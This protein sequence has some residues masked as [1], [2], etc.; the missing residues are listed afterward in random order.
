MKLE[1]TIKLNN[2]LDNNLNLEKMQNNF[3]D[4]TLGKV[5][6]GGIDLGLRAILPDFV[7]DQVISVKDSLVNAGLNNGISKTIEGAIN[8]GKNVLGIVTK[9]IQDV[10]QM[11]SIIKNGGLIG[12][13]SKVLDSTLNQA[14]NNN[15]INSNIYNKV[16]QGKK[17]ILN[18]IEQNIDKSIK[19]QE[20]S[21]NNLET[22]INNW[23][24]YYNNHDFPNMEKQY[25]KIKKELKNLIPLE[26]TISDAR[27]VENIHTLIKTNG[28][29]FNLDKTE[30]ELIKK[31]S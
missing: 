15:E 5:I 22:Y 27:T 7:E 13:I 2:N 21:F 26:K 28:K 3:L 25:K 4:S 20:N 23:K 17:D 18:N 19:E 9:G 1:N 16:M 30:L 6:N 29:D 31:L 11:Q 12:G 24:E 10:S 8:L 14:Q